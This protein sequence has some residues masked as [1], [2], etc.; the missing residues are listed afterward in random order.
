MKSTSQRTS[1]HTTQKLQ[2]QNDILCAVDQHQAVAL[3]LLDLSAAFDT[4]D[5]AFLLQRLSY[6]F[7]SHGKCLA[8][9]KSYLYNRTQR[10]S[11]QGTSSEARHLSYGVPQGSV[12]GP[13]LFVPYTSPLGDLIPRH[14]VRYHL[15][16]DDTQLY[17][18]FTPTRED[19]D[20]AQQKMEHCIDCI[21]AWMSQ[22]FLKLN[23]DKT[24]LAFCL[25]L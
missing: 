5:H 7:G 19:T 17:L 13:L 1:R 24:D 6:R 12:L 14:G 2:V 18:T 23:D 9:F 15:Y 22:T 10:V 20:N 8:W 25:L 3:V 16:A 4:I 11:I 21:R